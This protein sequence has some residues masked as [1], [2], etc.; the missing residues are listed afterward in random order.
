MSM[1]SPLSRSHLWSPA[2]DLRSSRP[3]TWAPLWAGERLPRDEVRLEDAQVGSHLPSACL[4][5]P[6]GLNHTRPPRRGPRP[7]R[8]VPSPPQHLAPCLHPPLRE[9]GLRLLLSL[10]TPLAQGLGSARTQ[11]GAGTSCLSFWIPAGGEARGW[12]PAGVLTDSSPQLQG[13]GCQGSWAHS[14]APPPCKPLGFELPSPTLPPTSRP[15][16]YSPNLP[17]QRSVG[18][19]A[20]MWLAVGL[21]PLS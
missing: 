16:W 5:L 9:G 3:P 6:F 21:T 17:A 18:V 8:A 7:S 13:G 11:G 14:Q 15:P 19:S 10:S 4:P 20:F 1:P 12:T 2:Q